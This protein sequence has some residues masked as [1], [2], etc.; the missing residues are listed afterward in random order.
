M[1]WEEAEAAGLVRLEVVPDEE[2]YDDSYIDTW[3]DLTPAQRKEAKQDLW[4]TIEREGVWGIVAHALNAQGKMV[5]VDSCWGY[6]GPLNECDKEPEMFAALA[7][8]D[9]YFT[10]EAEKMAARATFA[11]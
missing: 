11:G 7:F 2:A 5:E 6:V 4:R 1:K 9:G 8:L 3:D 10:A